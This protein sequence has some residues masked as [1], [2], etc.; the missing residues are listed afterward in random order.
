[1]KIRQNQSKLTKQAKLGNAAKPQRCKDKENKTAKPNSEETKKAEDIFAK[2][3]KKEAKKT[4]VGLRVRPPPSNAG[5]TKNFSSKD[6]DQKLV[7]KVAYFE[8]FCL[9]KYAS[10]TFLFQ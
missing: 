9:R 7:K 2:W 10:N 1:M 3:L 5:R 8:K 6:F 4:K